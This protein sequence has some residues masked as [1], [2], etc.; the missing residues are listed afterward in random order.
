MH[1]AHQSGFYS[2]LSQAL[3]RDLSHGVHNQWFQILAETLQHLTKNDPADQKYIVDIKYNMAQAFGLSFENGRPVNALLHHLAARDIGVI[4][5]IRRNKL[6][7][8]VSERVAM[9]TNQWEQSTQEAGKKE[10][11]DVFISPIT[12]GLKL[13]REMAQDAYFLEQTQSMRNKLTLTYEE[14]FTTDGSFKPRVF[15]DLARLLELDP[16]H[17]SLEPQL[18]KQR[19]KMSEAISNFPQVERAVQV[20]I[21]EGELPAYFAEGLE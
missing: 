8:L 21:R 4:Q 13:Q 17:F 10:Q 11:A 20:L 19:G 5:L 12:L 6:Q 7:L 3:S 1:P 2:Q 18:S 16:K 14:L 15:A 9:K